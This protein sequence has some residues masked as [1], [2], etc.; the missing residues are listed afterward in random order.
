MPDNPTGDLFAALA[1][2]DPHARTQKALAALDAGADVHAEHAHET[3]LSMLLAGHRHLEDG[4]FDVFRRLV[5]AGADVNY[6]NRDGHLILRLL[7]GLRAESDEARRPFYEVLFGTGRLDLSLPSN[8]NN[9]INTLKE[10]LQMNIEK[11]P[12]KLDVLAEFL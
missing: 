7:T 6:R 1:D 9:P 2:P 4:D 5:E 11:R 3:P 10:W 8:E 12:G